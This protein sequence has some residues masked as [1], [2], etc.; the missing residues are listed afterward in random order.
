MKKSNW[1]RKNSAI[2]KK[3]FGIET[4]IYET[5]HI[6]LNLSDDKTSAFVILSSSPSDRNAYAK[7]NADLARVLRT[8][9]NKDC[10]KEDFTI[11][12]YH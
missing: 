10:T 12:L 11:S 6:R 8:K 3:K 7:R 5:S 9:F 1:L 4:S 2:L